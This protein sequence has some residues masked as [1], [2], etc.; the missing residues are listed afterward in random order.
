MNT[1]I[2]EA[3][4]PIKYIQECPDSASES[5]T[6]ENGVEPTQDI[7]Q[8]QKVQKP[9]PLV[10]R[11]NGKL[12]LIRKEAPAKDIKIT[13]CRNTKEGIKIFPETATDFRRVRQLMDGKKVQCYIFR[14]KQEIQLKVVLEFHKKFRHRR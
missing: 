3:E 9:P 12:E 2:E 7:S 4:E 11:E 1:Q 14:L 10:L 5:T 13:S 8:S 6:E